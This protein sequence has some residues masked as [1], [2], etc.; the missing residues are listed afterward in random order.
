ML[1]TNK[2]A[3]NKI[4]KMIWI[5]SHCDT[6][7]TQVQNGHVSGALTTEYWSSFILGK[8]STII[9]CR[10]EKDK[11]IS[12]SMCKRLPNKNYSYK[13][14]MPTKQLK[15]NSTS[16]IHT[17]PNR[18]YLLILPNNPKSLTPIRSTTSTTPPQR[19]SLDSPPPQS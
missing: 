7:T 1:K 16:A 5:M 18:S 14:K 19:V 9:T 13:L 17:K 11:S 8:T 15:I 4:G 3:S 2:I 12:L 6:N 10:Y